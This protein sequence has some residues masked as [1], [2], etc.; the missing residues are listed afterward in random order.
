MIAATQP[1]LVVADEW[2]IDRFTHT[3]APLVLG[4]VQ[5]PGKRGE[6]TVA[7]LV[8]QWR[9]K[10]RPVERGEEDA[11]IISSAAGAGTRSRWCSR[12]VA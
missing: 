5:H 2:C 4:K 8:A 10:R 6:R 9:G 7:G 3:D 11:Q 12:S 1:T